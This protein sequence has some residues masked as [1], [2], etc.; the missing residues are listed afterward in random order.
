MR[1]RWRKVFVAGIFLV[2]PTLITL[3]LL[4]FLLNKIESTFTPW[5]LTIFPSLD[6]APPLGVADGHWEKLVP[7]IGLATF[8]VVIFLVGLLGSHYAGKRLINALE[9]TIL[10]VPLVKSI[11]G[12]AKQLFDALNASRGEDYNRVVLVEYP[13]RGLYTL[14]FVTKPLHPMV[15]APLE[16]EDL[17]FV[18]IPTTPN[19]TS[20][21]LI[22]APA[23]ELYD[24][25]L[26]IEAGMKTVVSGGMLALPPGELAAAEALADERA[27]AAGSGS[28]S[29]S[30]S[31]S[32][33]ALSSRSE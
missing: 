8:L 18:F 31:E 7:F 19:P 1:P 33:P 15:Q 32:E 6:Q 28:E 12:A 30:R 23:D 16:R 17:V 25:G 13:R 27:Q 20:G 9:Q 4:N 14:A 29:E 24:T 2:M 11:Y 5:F 22:A 26:S 10:K 21:F 3:F